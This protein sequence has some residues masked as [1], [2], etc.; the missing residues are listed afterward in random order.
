MPKTPKPQTGPVRPMLRLTADGQLT[1]GNEL[2]SI[3][4]QAPMS[5]GERKMF[6]AL[7]STM[8][9]L[10]HMGVHTPSPEALATLAVAA[11]RHDDMLTLTRTPVKL[12]PGK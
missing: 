12:E 3:S 1:G 6:N 5:E 7:A 2:P 9:V 4:P 10:H 11:M 8:R